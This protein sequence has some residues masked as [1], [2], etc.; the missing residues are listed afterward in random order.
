MI[1][2]SVAGVLLSLVGVASA[3]EIPLRDFAREAQYSQVK[4]SPTGEFMAVLTPVDGQ[5]S[6]GILRVA[7][8][9]IISGLRFRK[10]EEVADYVWSGPQRVMISIASRQ[11]ALVQ[12][13]RTGELMAMDADGKKKAY[14]F[15]YRG[16]DEVGSHIKRANKQYASARIL[17]PLPEDAESALIQVDYWNSKQAGFT[18]VLRINEYSGV[19]SRVTSAPITGR[20]TFLTDWQGKVRYALVRD[21]NALYKTFWRVA[22]KEDWQTENV[23]AREGAEIYP[24]N[25]TPDGEAVYLSSTED[26]DQRCLVKRQVQAQGAR[27]NLACGISDVIF[28]FDRREPIAVTRDEGRPVLDV[29]S[30]DHPQARQL[31]ALAK[32]FGGDALDIASRSRDGGK[33]LLEVTSDRNPGDYYLYDSATRK[34]EYLLSR[35]SWIEPKQMSERRPIKFTSR[36]GLAIQGYL[37]LP[38]G[39]GEKKLPLVVNPHGGPFGIRDTWHWDAEAQMLASRGYAVLQVNFRGSGGYGLAHQ[40]AGKKAWGTGMIDDIT[41]GARWAIAQG[42]AD[43][44][45]LCIYG[46]SYG[47]YAAMM[48]AVREPDLYQCVIGYVGVYDL[49]LQ[50]DETDTTQVQ[51]GRNYFKTHVGDSEELL[52]AQS[53]LS[54]IDRLKAPVFIVHG[55]EDKRVPFSQAEALREALDQR[56][57]PYEWLAKSGE[58]HGFYREDNR[59]E[60]YEQ[61]LA[62]LDRHI[63]AKVAP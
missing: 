35:R 57:H 58:G 26:G 55:K 33:V 24:L 50:E 3:A 4:L 16:E 5:S 7:D 19:T 52:K 10:G 62:F 9:Q 20:A 29:I 49:N 46:G 41:D 61:M 38:L 22:Q 54:H 51:W 14:L 17:D 23:G 42:Y 45:R 47:G 60:F 28:S 56:K 37:T 21:L 44:K 36:D 39:R 11:G 48:S 8:R 15:G 12:P 53:P 31:A 27:Q 63:G 2:Q 1:R 32:S 13:Q 6:L 59:V 30:P 40:R 34:A 43:A 25:F 18:E